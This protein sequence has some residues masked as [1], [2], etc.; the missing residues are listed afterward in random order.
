MQIYKTGFTNGFANAFDEYNEIN[1]KLFGI[2]EIDK[3]LSFKD[4]RNVCIANNSSRKATSNFLH[5]MIVNICINF[6][7]TKRND[8][9]GYSDLAE[10]KKTIIIDAGNGN[11]LGYIYLELVKASPIDGRTIK[12]LLKQIIIVRAFTFYQLLNIIINEIPKY[13]HEPDNHND[14]IQIIILDFLDTLQSPTHKINTKDEYSRLNYES[15][16]KNNESL[17]IEAVEVLLNLS[18]DYFV[19]LTYDNSNN[20][21]KDQ[22][23]CKFNN[24]LEIDEANLPDNHIIENKRSRDKS[25]DKKIE[26]YIKIKSKRI[27]SFSRFTSTSN[28]DVDD[29]SASTD[30]AQITV[31]DHQKLINI[32]V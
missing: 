28:C 9:G 8:S 11:N 32:G 4:E 15:D 29:E 30:D 25:K 24:G 23:L 12:E 13:I 16:F 7:L 18:R 31:T 10:K 22:L 26:L 1:R 21:V 20:I 14:K 5:S 17:V 19:I 2:P 3:F 6:H 27:K